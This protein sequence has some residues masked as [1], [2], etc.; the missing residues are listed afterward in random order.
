MVIASAF[1]F[2]GSQWRGKAVNFVVDNLAI[3]QVFN[4]TYSSN[5]HLMHIVHLL[6]FLASYHNIWFSSTHIAGKKNV[7]ADALSHNNVHSQVPEASLNH[8]RIPTALIS[9]LSQN[10]TW[11]STT[12]TK[13]FCIIIQQA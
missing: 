7:S 9:L 8:P 3:T 12:W 4:N 5:N 6:V 10:L 1:A 13:Q 2:Y 11:T